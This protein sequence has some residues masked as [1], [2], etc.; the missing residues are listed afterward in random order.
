MNDFG[1]SWR[2]ASGFGGSQVSVISLTGG[3]GGGGAT[4][5][6]NPSDKSAA[7]SLSSGNLTATGSSATFA[8]V[9]SI[10]SASSGKKYWEIHADTIN[11]TS[12]IST[13]AGIAASSLDFPAGYTSGVSWFSGG[14]IYVNGVS[15]TDTGISW[16]QGDTMCFAVDI[17]NNLLWIRANG[18]NWNANAGLD[19][20]SG[21]GGIDISTR[22]AGALFAMA[23]VGTS[24]SGNDVFTANFGATSYAFSVPSGFGNW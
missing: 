24:G 19:P 14:L 20:A 1:G 9:R 2:S 5:T 16:A 10:A 3:G 15:V 23:T 22:G 6:W 21:S 11:A 7:I 8:G 17:D 4:T 18:G 13:G 12:Q